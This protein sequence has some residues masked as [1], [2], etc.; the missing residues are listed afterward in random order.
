LD[1][2]KSP[3][4]LLCTVFLAAVLHAEESTFREPALPVIPAHSF[5]IVDH[6]AKGDGATDNTRAVQAAIDAA[7]AA[8]GGK[9]IVPG[10]EFLCGPIKMAN[11]VELH[12]E[13][14]AV[15]KMLPMEQYPGGSA[16]PEDFIRGSKLED[17]ALSGAG[18]IDG[19]GAPWWPLA[20]NK[21]AKR[22]IMI[23][24]SRCQRVLIDGV[25]LKNSPMFHI[26]VG[27]NS[28]E[29]TVRGVTIRAPGSDDP[30]TPGH[31]TDACD[32]SGSHILIR[33]CDVSVGDD[34]FTCAGGT[35]DVLITH[36]RYGKGHGVSIGSPTHGGVTNF[37]VSDCTFDGTES[38][39]RIKSDRDRGGEV[40]HLT[41]RNLR[42]TNV[43][44]PILVYAAYMATQ[45]EYRDLNK[46][47]PET[48]AAYPAAEVTNRTP[49]YHDIT[50]SDITA[51]AQSGRRAGLIWGLPEAPVRDL[52]L[53]NV[54]ITA[55]RPLGIYDAQGV[56]VEHC[57]I[58]TPENVEPLESVNAQFEG[59]VHLAAAAR[60]QKGK[61]GSVPAP[62]PAVVPK[63]VLM[64]A[65]DGSGDFKTLQEAL[66]AVPEK[67]GEGT[68][69]HLKPGVYEG[70]VV[71][72]VAKR[73]M[74]FEGD[75]AERTIIT[76]NRNMKD[77]VPVGIDGFNPGVQILGDGF[78][79]EN[80]TF[81]NTSGD[82]GQGVAV[83]V[84]A[85]RVVFQKCRF[86]GW[87]DT[88]MLNRGRQYF[89]ECYIEGRVD[90]I[91]GDGT[92]VL[93]HCQVHSKNGGFIT[94]ASTPAE[95]PFGFVFLHC[96]LTGDTVPWVNPDANADAA[97]KAAKLPNTLL[98]RPWRPHASVAF[99]QCEMGAHLK[100]GGWDN[101]GKAENEGTARFVEFGNTGPGAAVEGRVPW[102]KRLTADDAA[103]ITVSA[104]LAGRDGWKP[105]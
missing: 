30:V 4:L 52:V 9:V 48:A 58:V 87:Q 65:A 2:V 75:D 13:A 46:L 53:R 88:L 98:G 70:P 6:G 17:I 40:S 37:T 99:I 103:K 31:N 66:A 57:E 20:K 51:T 50:F 12:L 79:A 22:P 18:T 7:S 100:P 19:Q 38:G 101:W 54:H 94:A 93:D 28:T 16:T 26:A 82:R 5:F 61:A 39:I 36:C 77:P 91:F 10:G 29:I 102:A 25:T 97:K 67:G 8:G 92:A 3:F 78:R 64:V 83:R 86:L 90:F 95:K 1:V 14:G 62:A 74:S 47:S 27:G 44:F 72:P 60:L 59:T 89:R 80:L 69:L 49:L 43:G 35:S 32:V 81:Q 41:F 73:R 33:D 45:R 42:M 84:D 105:E 63:R 68:V 11:H 104:V 34:D 76:W 71:V 56:R 96:Q 24:L 55:D 23:S 85:D 21:E 15:L